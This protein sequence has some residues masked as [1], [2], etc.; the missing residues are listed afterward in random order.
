M[1]VSFSTDSWWL[2]SLILM[3]FTTIPVKIAATV[4]NAPKK[5]LIHCALAVALGTVSTVLCLHFIGGFT[6]LFVSFVAIS[7]IYWYILQISFAWSFVFT[8]FVIVIQFA[9]MHGLA[10]LGLMMV[11]Q[12]T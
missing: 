10:Q 3:I 8:I 12:S 7:T 9:L 2:I 11:A 5:T 4:F 6:A 1:S